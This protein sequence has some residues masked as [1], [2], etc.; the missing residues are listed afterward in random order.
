[1]STDTF[2]R[3]GTLDTTSDKAKRAVKVF[4]GMLPMLSAYARALTGDD[5]VQVVLSKESNGSTDGKKIFFRPPIELAEEREHDRRLCDRR[6]DDGQMICDACRLREDILTVIYHEIAHIAYGT[7]KVPSAESVARA[8]EKTVADQAGEWGHGTAHRVAMAPY[9][10][11]RDWLN[12]SS[13]VSPYLPTLVNA[14]EDSRVNALMFQA[15]PGVKTMFEALVE[16]I[17]TNGFESSDGRGGVKTVRWPEQPLNAQICVGIFAKISGYDYETWFAPQIIEAL[18]DPELTRILKGMSQVRSAKGV[19]TLSIPV[20]VRLRE[21]GFM[22]DPSDVDYTEPEP[23]PEEEPEETD[24]QGDSDE[25]EPDELDTDEPDAGESEEGGDSDSEDWEPSPDTGEGSEDEPDDATAGDDGESD[26]DG[27]SGESEDPGSDAADD[28]M[29]EGG[30]GDDASDESGDGDAVP[31]EQSADDESEDGDPSDE[32]SEEGE[33]GPSGDDSGEESESTGGEAGS[34]T[35]AEDDSE[36]DVSD[37]DYSSDGSDESGSGTGDIERQEFG[38]DA[39]SDP[40]AG[41]QGGDGAYSDPS[42]DTPGAEPTEGAS[43]PVPEHPDDPVNDDEGDGEGTSHGDLGDPDDED[44]ATGVTLLDNP[45][46]DGKSALDYGTPEEAQEALKQFGDHA[47]PPSS[48]QEGDY[49]KAV[50]VAI[51]QSIYFETESRFVNGVRWHKFG[52][53]EPLAGYGDYDGNEAWSSTSSWNDYVKAHDLN[54]PESVIG[55]ALG[56]LRVVLEDNARGKNQRN[57]KSGKVN[58]KV[59]GRRAFHGDERLFKKKTLPG[60]R[61]YFVVIGID[62][63]GSTV[64]TNIELEK[65]AVM[66]Q[67]NMLDRLG[68]PFSIYAHSGQYD[69]VL[70]GRESGIMLEIYPIREAGEAW[71][72]HT[73][74]RLQELGSASANLDGHAL[75]FLRKRAD[76]S[77]A[78]D[79]IILYYSDGKMPAENHDEELEILQREIRTCAQKGYALLGVGIRTDSPREHGLDTVEVHDDGDL[80]KVIHHL[81]KKLA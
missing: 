21:M 81:E 6:G 71:D 76:E 67:A 47:D 64:G 22:I 48:V 55:P 9:Y 72:K 5:A 65:R 52:V 59:L 23:E 12:I 14:L 49:E 54:I 41:G 63:S 36:G 3:T 53:P 35:D 62:V 43:P 78:T 25:S 34:P 68:I 30:S 17:F 56:K 51:N 16:K 8:I 10:K 1:M 73:Q 57:L 29:D 40:T 45:N 38:D 44:D 27:E 46:N 31:S 66:A 58:A 24:E 70:S 32:P 13:L 28:S 80:I 4:R 69:N 26:D 74:Q 75:E 2:S 19:Y 18:E 42:G 33:A 61:N 20:L 79:K 39:D 50:G 11:K 37:D 60:K 15:R 77:K 7:F